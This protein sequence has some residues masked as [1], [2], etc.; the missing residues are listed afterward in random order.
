MSLTRFVAIALLLVG[1]AALSVAPAV[2][3]PKGKGN[4]NG[5]SPKSA[6][7]T[8]SITLNEADPHFGDTVTFTVTYPDTRYDARV[9][10][11]CFQNGEFVYQYSQGSE[12]G[13]DSWVPTFTLWDYIWYSNGGGPA[14]CTADLYYYTWKGHTQTGV[15]YLAHTEFT[16]AE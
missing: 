6:S 16:A 2:A 14:E 9:A 11:A 8:A 5:N 15:V 13:E 3:G 12:K 1:V 10:V 4:G 7:T